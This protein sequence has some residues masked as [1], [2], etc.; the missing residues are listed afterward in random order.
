M[1][2]INLIHT[3]VDPSFRETDNKIK[4]FFKVRE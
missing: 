1:R 3:L 2:Q 4:F